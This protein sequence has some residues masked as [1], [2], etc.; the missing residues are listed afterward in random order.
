MWIEQDDA[1]MSC[2]LK[3][4]THADSRAHTSMH[5]EQ[6]GAVYLILVMYLHVFGA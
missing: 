4:V 1:C 3:A 5:N 2:S 6:A